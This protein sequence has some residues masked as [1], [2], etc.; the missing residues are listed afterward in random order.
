[1]KKALIFAGAVTALALTSAPASA[2]PV[3]ATTNAT[4]TARIYTPLTLTS[5]RDLDLGTI[6]LSGTGPYTD[7]VGIDQAGTFSCG[8]NVTC[9]GTTQTAQYEAT[10]TMD[11]TLTITV[12]ATLALVNQT[13]AAP[14]L[15]LNVDAPATVVLDGSGYVLFDIGGS[16]DVS[17]TTLDGVYQGTFDVEADYQ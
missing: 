13:Q 8:A 7:T 1:M 10:G 3:P 16:I 2:A 9:S 15:T 11:Q 5:V 4:A 17:D 6:V 14:D 12:P